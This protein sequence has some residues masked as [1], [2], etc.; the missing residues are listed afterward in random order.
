MIFQ[1][2]MSMLYIRIDD[3]YLCLASIAKFCDGGFEE[4]IEEMV[5]TAVVRESGGDETATRLGTRLVVWEETGDET[6]ATAGDEM[7]ATCMVMYT[8]EEELE[9]D[10]D[11]MAAFEGQRLVAEFKCGI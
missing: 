5:E 2:Y 9:F 8:D 3:R 1:S 6:A 7:A 4:N 10:K 11:K